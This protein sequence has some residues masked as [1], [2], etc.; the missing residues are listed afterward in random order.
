[1]IFKPLDTEKIFKNS[2]KISEMDRRDFLKIGLVITGVFAGGS[3]VS[4]VSAAEKI[5][6]SGSYEE[7]YP[8]NRITVWWSAWIGVSAAAFA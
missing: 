6:P 2:E 1:M 4:A 3:I 8:Y 7:K 5:F